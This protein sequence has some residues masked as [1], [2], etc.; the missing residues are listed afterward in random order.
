MNIE[1]K[2]RTNPDISKMK[3]VNVCSRVCWASCVGKSLVLDH[4]C[5][6]NNPG[7]NAWVHLHTAFF[8]HSKVLN[9]SKV[10]WGFLTGEQ[11][12]PNSCPAPRFAP[13]ST[14]L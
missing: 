2:D 6:L 3:T 4:S 9:E 11:C 7:L 13:G 14:V 1:S 12:V 8:H 5:P 10:I